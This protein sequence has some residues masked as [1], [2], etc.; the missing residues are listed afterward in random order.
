LRKVNDLLSQIKLALTHF[1][2][3]DSGDD[4]A[5]DARGDDKKNPGHLQCYSNLVFVKCQQYINIFKLIAV[6][7][8]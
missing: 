2:V 8:F 4:L 5:M 6:G 1:I 3:A 7:M